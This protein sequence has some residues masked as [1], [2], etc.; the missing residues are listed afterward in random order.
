MNKPIIVPENT[1][2]VLHGTLF[3]YSVSIDG[4]IQL[5]KLGAYDGKKKKSSAIK[6][7]PPTLEQCEKWFPDF[8]KALIKQAWQYY[9]DGK[10]DKGQWTDKNGN[11]VVN[12]KQK[13]RNNWMKDDRKLVAD[14]SNKPKQPQMV[15]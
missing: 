4:N 13:L 6:N 3:K 2:F 5:T 15:R 12:Y 1:E 10:N 11:I 14:D 8:P 9:E 7:P